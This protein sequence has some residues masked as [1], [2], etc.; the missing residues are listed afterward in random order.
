[1][2]TTQKSSWSAWNASSHAMAKAAAFLLCVDVKVLGAKRGCSTFDSVD[3]GMDIAWSG[4]HWN[5]TRIDAFGGAGWS[6]NTR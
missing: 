1:M 5:G 3:G 2:N 4:G 6:R